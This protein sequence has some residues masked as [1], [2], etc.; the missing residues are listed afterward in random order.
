[1]QDMDHPQM[2]VHKW[3]GIALA[4]VLPVLL[5]SRWRGYRKDEAP[6]WAYLAYAAAVGA[7]L[8]VQGHLGGTMTFG[9][10]P[11]APP[12]D[13]APDGSAGTHPDRMSGMGQMGHASHGTPPASA[14]KSGT[15]LWKDHLDLPG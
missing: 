12:S 9:N 11:D 15:I 10:E 3:L 5:W 8:V 7:V 14:P 2:P 1:M 13:P 4:V 6:G